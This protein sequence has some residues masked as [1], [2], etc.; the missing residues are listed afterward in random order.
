MAG[1]VELSE[2]YAAFIELT[3]IVYV[4][5]RCGVGGRGWN[6]GKSGKTTHSVW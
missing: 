1:A 6:S 2:F 4:T 5:H 3:S